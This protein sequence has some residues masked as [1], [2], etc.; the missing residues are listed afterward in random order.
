MVLGPDG[1]QHAALTGIGDLSGGR[2]GQ[3]NVH[4]EVV[5]GGTAE[6]FRQQPEAT[7]AERLTV[8]REPPQPW[9]LGHS[10]PLHHPRQAQEPPV[11]AA[12]AGGENGVH[13]LR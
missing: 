6:G 4:G 1:G 8:N 7:P 12:D 3:D 11:E 10:R 2:R 9:R 13:D 5:S